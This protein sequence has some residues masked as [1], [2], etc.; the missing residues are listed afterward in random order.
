MRKISILS[1]CLFVS[2]STFAQWSLTG[3]AGTNPPTNFVGTTDNERLVFKSNAGEGMT[4]LPSLNVGIGLTAPINLL[5]VY[6][7]TADFHAGFSGTDP[8]IH[9]FPGSTIVSG[10][11]L[12]KIGLATGA[13]A[14]VAG[15][16]DGDF[17]M[18]QSDTVHSIIFAT[19][20]SS[21]NGLERMRINKIGYVGIA[22]AS[23]TAKF[24]VNCVAV[25]GQTN[26]SNIRFENLQHGGGAYLVIDS[27]GYVYRDTSTAGG[28]L[29]KTPLVTDMQS[30]LED[31]QNQVQELRSLLSNRLALSSAEQKQ[32]Q[33]ESAG[34]LGDV[35]P[36]PATSSTT[37]DYSLPA[38]AGAAF[39]QIYGLS[40]NMIAAVSLPTA[41]GKSQVQ[42]NTAQL[43]A[44]MYIYALVVDGK[45][46]ATK[47][48]VVAR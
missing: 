17:I 47:K 2:V 23:P 44:G 32:L 5:H 13:N 40:G 43:A 36:N 10:A 45:V 46:L 26:P 19:N 35:H 29:A 30:Q 25:S 9:F 4:L 20:Q 42:V 11:P 34:W 1:L 8:A 3:N 28:A 37:I 39:C 14:F 18:Q 21:G 22:Q 48:L 12:G 16:A 7:T 15:S 33:N 31:L 24:D 41:Q 38:G 27:N 6:S